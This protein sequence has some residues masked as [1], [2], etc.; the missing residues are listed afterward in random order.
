[1]LMAG[2][3]PVSAA[4][5]GLFFRSF[6]RLHPRFGTPYVALVASSIGA[7]L[8]LLLLLRSS[9][10]D[11]FQFVLQ[12]AVV[13]TLVPHLASTAADFVLAGRRAGQRAG[14]SSR[15]ARIQAAIAFLFVAFTI[16]GCGV[17]AMSWGAAVL[18]V[19]VP[20]YLGLRRGNVG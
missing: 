18:V 5:D 12:L 2:R 15:G 4:H 3:I 14:A 7:S 17:E 13:T 16:Y 9:L 8:V 6:A 19:G 10:A 20:I 11:V 1:V